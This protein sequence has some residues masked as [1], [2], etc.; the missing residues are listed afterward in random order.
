[1][2]VL[3][4][5]SPSVQ[6][7]LAYSII[8][9]NGNIFIGSDIKSTLESYMFAVSR[10]GQEAW[11]FHTQGQVDYPVV[12]SD[13][14]VYVNNFYDSLYAIN[15]QG[16]EKWVF[17]VDEFPEFGSAIQFFPGL[18][19]HAVGQNDDIYLSAMTKLYKL[20]KDGSVLWEFEPQGLDD[21]PL[22][23]VNPVIDQNGML[24]SVF[25]NEYFSYDPGYGTYANIYSI[26]PDGTSGWVITTWSKIYGNSPS[27]GMD[28]RLYVASQSKLFSINSD[29]NIDWMLDYID[30]SMG[31]P[32]YISTPVI[33]EDGTV[34]LALGYDYEG[35]DDVTLFS[36]I[37]REG[38]VL[39]STELEEIN[40]SSPVIGDNGNIYLATGDFL[41]SI[42][43][44][45]SVNQKIQIN[46]GVYFPLVMD[47]EGVLYL[48]TK[49]EGKL[50]AVG[51]SSSGPADS[52]WPM[53]GHDPQHT[54]NQATPICQ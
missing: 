8:G 9:D 51:T 41:Y 29:G 6:R 45:G 15:H 50:I 7:D 3:W 12:G 32:V 25:T 36:A 31:F 24:Y 43:R 26:Y 42:S 35:P 21:K 4:E 1:M 52:P 2:K 19:F 14:T 40:R 16:N 30:F 5:F 27:I 17:R 13:G 22:F 33:G 53:Y 34:Y 39:W 48:S 38:S 47:C 10:D 46:G 11:S 37:D 18:F 54:G 44:N 28:N 23:G 20:G 49:V